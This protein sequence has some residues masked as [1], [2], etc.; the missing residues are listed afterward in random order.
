MKK[1]LTLG[2]LALAV[3]SVS[4]SEAPAWLNWKFGIGANIGWQSGG[5]NTLWGLFRNGQPPAPD[6]CIGG[7]FGPGIPPGLPGPGLPG[8][9]PI[10]HT[11][12]QPNSLDHN[13][14]SDPASASNIPA[15]PQSF[16]QTPWTGQTVNY[17]YPYS[18]PY[19]YNY[20]YNYN[21]YGY[22]R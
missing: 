14:A 16:T 17:Q 12:Y 13:V 3:A 9:G 2:V 11:Y 22:G 1:F 15:R 19:Y 21:Y 6:A 8:P 7:G 5:N 20:G 18:Y 4:T 10:P